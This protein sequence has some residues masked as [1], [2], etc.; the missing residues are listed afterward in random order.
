MTDDWGVDSHTVEMRY[1]W[2]FGTDRYLQPHVRF[3]HK[4]PR[5]SIARCYSTARRCQRSLRLITA[6]ASSTD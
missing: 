1:R 6:S 5:T 2:S 4:P 3:Y